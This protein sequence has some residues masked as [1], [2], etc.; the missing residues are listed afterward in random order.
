MSKT[1]IMLNTIEDHNSCFLITTSMTL[2]EHTHKES[3]LT[4]EVG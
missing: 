4:L 1:R 3:I 2:L